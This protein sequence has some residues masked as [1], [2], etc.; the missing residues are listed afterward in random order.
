MSDLMIQ[1]LHHLQDLIYQSLE[2]KDFDS[3]LKMIQDVVMKMIKCPLNT[4]FVFSSAVLDELCLKIGEQICR[5]K[6]LLNIDYKPESNTVIYVVTKLY[7]TGGGHIGVI[8]DCIQLRPDQKHVILITDILPESSKEE[9]L[10]RF[11][12]LSAE[13]IWAP[14]VSLTDKVVWLVNQIASYQPGVV[15][16]FQHHHDSVAIAALQPHVHPYVIFYHHGDHRLCLGVHVPHFIHVDPHPMGFH[17][18]RHK[19]GIKKNIYWPLCALD[20]GCRP[21][22][23]PFM[24]DGFLKTCS[25]GRDTKFEDLYLY[26]YAELVPKIIKQTGGQ[27]LHIGPLSEVTLNSIYR[28]LNHLQIPRQRFIHIPWVKSVWETLIQ[29]QVDLYITSF[30]HGGGK[31]SIEA[32]G[33]GTPVIAHSHYKSQFLAGECLIYPEG[34]CWRKPDQLFQY[35]TTITPHILAE[36]SQYARAHYARYHRPEILQAELM[37][38]PSEMKGLTCPSLPDFQQDY[39]QMALENAITYDPDKVDPQL[40]ALL[41]STSWR[42]TAPLRTVTHYCAKL[43][44]LI[45]KK[46]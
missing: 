44:D 35:L 38:H 39:F 13:F 43:K 14:S 24:K 8:A 36:Q 32:M 40:Q 28:D 18:C 15:F 41:N 22:Q 4:A 7:L 19:L 23:Q 34:F 10:A 9:L 25:S 27:H 11:S 17:N 26:R 42:L 45:L 20:K 3:A 29:E 21:P 16:L 12:N 37:K 2:R 6:K 5:E 31:V 46:E 33:S 1:S 30:P